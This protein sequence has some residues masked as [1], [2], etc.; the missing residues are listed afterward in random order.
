MRFHRTLVL[1]ASLLMALSAA[2]VG[3]AS[4][5]L[6]SGPVGDG[7]IRVGSNPWPESEI[8]AEI[9]AQAL[10]AVDIPVQRK[11]DIGS[12]DVTWAALQS[13]KDINLMPEY[14]FSFLSEAL[15]SPD[16]ATS[17]AAQTWSNLVA[18]LAPL[19]FSVLS[20]TPAVDTNAFTV[21]AETAQKYSLA[22]IGDL[23]K[24]AGELK[25][26]LP[27]NCATNPSCADALKQYGIDVSALQVTE[28][29][30][31]SPE[32]AT[33]L[34]SG[35]I[36][37]GELCST[38]AD[39][40]VNGLVVLTDDLHTQGA[41]N[42]SPIVRNDA[43]RALQAQGKDLAAILD[44]ISATITTEALT[45]L[46]VRVQVNHEDVDAVARDFLVSRGLLSV[47]SATP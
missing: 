3:E 5:P 7:T 10:E 20:Y 33:T 18:A 2:A 23:A 16:L 25:W 37:V 26:G 46:I 8:M 1:G 42:M 21:T 9:Y 31:C 34:V 47:S 30:A 36:Q 22:S 40:A 6:P 38:Q 4:S 44:P 12:R 45:D 41:D 32:M 43:L 17:D 13:G 24:V 19:D 29:G 15:D 11:P 35:G 28:L 14:I 27:S 39:I